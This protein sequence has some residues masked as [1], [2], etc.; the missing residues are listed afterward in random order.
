MSD[1]KEELIDF[2]VKKLKIIGEQLSFLLYPATDAVSWYND[3][4]D[5]IDISTYDEKD[6]VRLIAYESRKVA[7][8]QAVKLTAR[9]ELIHIY[10]YNNK[11]T[12][13]CQKGQSY[14]FDGTN[15]HN[16]KK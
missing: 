11:A 8:Y 5:Y 12:Y 16:K 6:A 7:P 2:G 10:V 4:S 3:T 9:G 1:S 14:L 13:D 15:V